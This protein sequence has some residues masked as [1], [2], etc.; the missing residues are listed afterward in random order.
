MSVGANVLLPFLTNKK[1]IEGI[2][3]YFLSADKK[4][5]AMFIFVFVLS[6]IVCIIGQKSGPALTGADI[7]YI[8]NIPCLLLVF[9]VCVRHYSYSLGSDKTRQMY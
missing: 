1:Y 6:F 3:T 2:K 8:Y 5:A 4:N 9:T 7:Y